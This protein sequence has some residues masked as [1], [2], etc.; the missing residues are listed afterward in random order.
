MLKPTRLL[1]ED[2][3]FVN[4]MG[5]WMQGQSEIERGHALVFATFLSESCLTIKDTQIKFLQPDVSVARVASALAGKELLP[6]GN[7]VPEGET[8]KA[9]Q[10]VD[11]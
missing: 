5:L 10:S 9:F 8:L 11:E 2:S 4:V 6:H 7:H 3:D 1:T